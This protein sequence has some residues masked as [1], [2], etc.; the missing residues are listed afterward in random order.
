MLLDLQQSRWLT[1]IR[2]LVHCYRSKLNVQIT[3]DEIWMNSALESMKEKC[4][5]ELDQNVTI[6]A[7]VAESIQQV[8]CPNECFARQGHGVCVTGKI[9]SWKY[10]IE[11]ILFLF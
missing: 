4:L 9:S 3:N 1:G 7:S 5:N 2:T 6:D 11:D 8:S 10:I